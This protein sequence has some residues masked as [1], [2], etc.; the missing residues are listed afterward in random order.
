MDAP[1]FQLD[2]AVGWKADPSYHGKVIS[3]LIHNTPVPPTHH[4]PPYAKE[5]QYLIYLDQPPAGEKQLATQ[6]WLT[7][8]KIQRHESEK[9]KP[10]NEFGIPEVQDLNLPDPLC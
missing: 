1:K 4:Q 9:E 7:E 2:Q 3:I 10:S 8:D 5:W 6:M